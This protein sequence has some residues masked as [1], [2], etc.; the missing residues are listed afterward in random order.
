MIAQ[1]LMNLTILENP[2][3]KKVEQEALKQISTNDENIIC[4]HM[5]MASRCYW[6]KQLE[7]LR[8][9]T[10]RQLSFQKILMFALLH[11]DLLKVSDIGALIIELVENNI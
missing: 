3:E 5:K 2:I 4:V 9:L 1:K 6:D 7:L 11:V 8:N 10:H